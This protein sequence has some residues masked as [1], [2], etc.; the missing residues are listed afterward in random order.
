MILLEVNNDNGMRSDEPGAITEVVEGIR[1]PHRLARATSD[2]SKH[3]H[4]DLYQTVEIVG[5]C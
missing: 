4:S 1:Y 5:S 3:Q 2:I